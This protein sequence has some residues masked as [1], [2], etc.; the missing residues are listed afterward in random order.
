MP[1]QIPPEVA[2]DIGPFLNRLAE[3]GY[4]PTDSRYSSES[5]G[6]YY[7]DLA[8]KTSW[9]R[10]QRD[11]SQYYVNAVT[12][13]RRQNDGILRAF[14]DKTEFEQAVLDWLSAA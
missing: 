11:R 14:D 6:N 10:I 7:V 13:A 4:Q 1:H 2:Q 12:A 5:F 8:S 3:F 9:M